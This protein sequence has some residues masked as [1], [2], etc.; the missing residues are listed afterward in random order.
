MGVLI[1]RSTYWYLVRMIK[2]E[3]NHRTFDGMREY[4]NT[5]LFT[6]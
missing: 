3:A 6:S 2:L 5:I 4:L 1:L